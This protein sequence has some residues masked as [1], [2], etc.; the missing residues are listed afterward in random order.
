VQSEPL[1]EFFFLRVRRHQHGQ[2]PETQTFFLRNS[3][4]HHHTLQTVFHVFHD[5]AQ[6]VFDELLE[7]CFFR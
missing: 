5:A 3:Y 7:A 2:A 1:K 6:H 4:T